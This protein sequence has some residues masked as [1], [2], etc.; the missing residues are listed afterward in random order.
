MERSKLRKRII[1]GVLMLIF[2][3][4]CVIGMTSA[5]YATVDNENVIRLAGANRFE[6]S[7]IISLFMF[8][9]DE[10]EAIV[11]VNGLDYPDALAAAPFAS[12][13]NAPILM[14]N[15][16]AGIFEPSVAAEIERIDS[17]HNAD[18]Y[19]IGGTG[20]VNETV[21][22][23]LKQVGYENIT[24]IYGD[25]RFETAVK[26]AKNIRGKKIAFIAN[27]YNYPDALGAGSAAAL[28]N[29][30][31]LFTG[32]DTL[33][34][35]TKEYL[36][37]IA[38]DTVVILGGEGAITPEVE[39]EICELQDDVQRVQGSDRYV[40]CIAL[41]EICFPKTD[42]VVVATGQD[43]ADALAGGPFATVYNAPIL[44]LN[45][46]LDHVESY[47]REYIERSG[48]QNIAVLGGTG[49]ISEELY[50]DLSNIVK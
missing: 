43:F 6:T 33:N 37:H 23:Q 45:P 42:T 49:V 19:I 22:E 12:S 38:F 14:V 46:Y 44:L 26:V 16:P 1:T 36:E 35:D 3:A 7:A 13:V 5:S 18:I 48:A 39:A 11:L 9:D 24:R 17:N 41:A 40:T 25:D 50:E 34:E 28:N 32:S 4:S 8:E 21:I 30:V 27:G 15:G 10:A 31:I 29:G 2:T 20:A 47:I